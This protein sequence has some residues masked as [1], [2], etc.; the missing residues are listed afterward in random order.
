MDEGYPTPFLLWDRKDVKRY[1]T[2]VYSGGDDLFLIGHWLDILESSFDINAALRR[3]TANPYITV[4]G[5]IILGDSHDP[6]YH[7]A[8]QAHTCLLY[9]SDAADDLLCVDIGGRRIIKKKTHKTRAL[10]ISHTSL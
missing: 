3:L 6:I 9:T 2:I 5:G 4:S 7:L 8:H 10:L 1:L